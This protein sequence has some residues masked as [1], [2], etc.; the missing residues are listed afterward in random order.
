M[1]RVFMTLGLMM[2]AVSACTSQP[3][4]VEPTAAPAAYL[5]ESETLAPLSNTQPPSANVQPITTASTTTTAYVPIET[6]RSRLVVN[7]VGDVNLDPSFVGSFATKGYADAWSGIFGAFRRDDLTIVNLECSPS[8]L[9]TPWPKTW[10][11]RCAVDALPAMADAGVDIANLANNHAMDYGFDAMLDGRQNLLD[12]GILPV[13]T[14]RDVHAAYTPVIV[15]RNGW[16]IAVIGSGGV[17]PE[18]GSWVAEHDRPGM[19][20]GDDTDS[21]AEAVRQAALIADLVFVTAH[22]GEQDTTRPLAF[23]RRQA[24]AW[25][26]AGADG[27]FGHHQHV[28]QP[29]EWYQ[30]RP[31]A[32]GLGNFVWQ[33][34]T[35]EWRKTAIAQFVFEADGRISACLIPVTI[36]RNAHPVIL[37]PSAPVCAPPD[38]R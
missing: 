2:V 10:N 35:P 19:T 5:A 22:W 27:I 20:N 30:G 17:H 32:W 23:E 18:S 14:G 36:D 28:L 25:I 24:E 38:P 13:G 31:I 6:P 3:Q 12:V 15:E 4:S 7:G 8:A 16:T 34:Y 26:D 21:I 11:F 37:D 33:A 1:K 9:G 29:L